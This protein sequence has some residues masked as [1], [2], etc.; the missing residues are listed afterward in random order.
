MYQRRF[1][2]PNLATEPNTTSDPAAPPDAPK[3]DVVRP[4]ETLDARVSIVKEGDFEL[5][6]TDL[7]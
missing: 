3:W 1:E 6:A 5:E 7:E 2:A 4:Q